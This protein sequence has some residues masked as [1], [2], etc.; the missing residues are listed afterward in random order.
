[1]SLFWAKVHTFYSQWS[2]NLKCYDQIYKGC[3]NGIYRVHRFSK[4][5]IWRVYI[6]R[7]KGKCSNERGITLASNFGKVYERLLN[8]RV[9]KE[10]HITEAQG[11]GITGNATVDHLIVLKEAIRQIRKRGKTAYV[12]FLDVQKAY[13]KAWLDAILYTMKRMAYLEKT[14]KWWGRWIRDLQLESEQS[15]GP[16]ER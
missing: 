14:W 3:V 9:K 5:N 10:V 1:M 12:A 13:D 2:Q 15:M 7:A 11:G 4:T 6:T 16:Q 8:E